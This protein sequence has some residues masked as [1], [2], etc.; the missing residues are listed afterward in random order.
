MTL[1]NLIYWSLFHV[2]V[3][4]LGSTEV[5]KTT[6]F[7]DKSKVKNQACFGGIGAN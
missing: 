7:T 1:N 2:Y 5:N 4:Y 3:L 6:Q